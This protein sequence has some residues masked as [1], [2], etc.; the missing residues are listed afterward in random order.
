MKY[1]VTYDV[2]DD[3]TRLRIAEILEGFGVRVQKSV[4]ECRL[5][6]RAVEILLAKLRRALPEPEAGNVRIYRLCAHCEAAALGLGDVEQ[7]DEGPAII[8]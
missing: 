5:G 6:E 8:L 1:V 4:F 2:S 3:R 7:P